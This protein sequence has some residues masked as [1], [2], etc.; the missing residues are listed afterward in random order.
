MRRSEFAE[1]A[2]H[3]FGSSLARTYTHDLVLEEVGGLTAAEAIREA[4][5]KIV[6]ELVADVVDKLVEDNIT[7]PLIEKVFG[8]SDT[9]EDVREKGEIVKNFNERNFSLV[10]EG[11]DAVGSDKPFDVEEY[12]RKLSDSVKQFFSDVFSNLTGVSQDKADALFDLGSQISAHGEH[13][14]IGL[15]ATYNDH[16]LAQATVFADGHEDTYL[17][18]R[19]AN[20]VRLG[21]GNDGALGGRGDDVLLGEEGNDLL[22]GGFGKDKLYGG[23]G[24]DALSGGANE[25]RLWG[26]AGNDTLAGGLAADVLVGGR[27]RDVLSG[28][29]GADRFVFESIA[30][31]GG[32]TRAGADTISD[33]SHKQGDRIDV[34]AIDAKAGGGTANDAFA[35]LG[36]GAF[37]GHAGE[38][39]YTQ[40]AAFTL[41]QGDVNGDGVADFAL[42]LAGKIGLVAADLIL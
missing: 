33:F 40:G 18:D 12:D 34:S 42:T 24:N 26:E 15:S 5:S 23:T 1:L 17:G 41:V 28:G 35:W 31:F 27:G 8:A 38:L 30:D 36:K 32:R 7:S 19:F 20:R 25:D 6:G 9:V 21:D 29:G 3:V 4:G 2:D 14:V 22:L 39:R 37:T 10:Q 13:S 16:A 11:I